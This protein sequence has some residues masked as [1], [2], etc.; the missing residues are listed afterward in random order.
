MNSMHRGRPPGGGREILHVI[1]IVIIAVLATPPAATAGKASPEDG[2][3]AQVQEDIRR[4]EYAVSVTTGGHLS[5]PNRA[6]DLRTQVDGRGFRVVSRTRGAAAFDVTVRLRALG[7]DAGMQP[8]AGEGQTVSREARLEILRDGGLVEWLVN[9][10]NGLEHGFVLEAPPAAG[11]AGEAVLDLELQGSL[12][13]YPLGRRG[14]MLKR[15][16]CVT[17]A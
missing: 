5:A 17:T 8:V 13:P 16:S 11:G 1:I 3:L 4:Q 14:V 2:W 10:E 15:T 7:R 12:V 6:H 9:D